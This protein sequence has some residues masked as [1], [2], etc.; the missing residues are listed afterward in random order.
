MREIR[1]FEV[2]MLFNYEDEGIKDYL[3]SAMDDWEEVDL[4]EYYDLQSWIN[5][6]NQ[7]KSTK[8][9][10]I[11]VSPNTNTIMKTC[12]AD[13]KKIRKE[14]EIRK[15]KQEEIAKKRAATVKLKKEKK[16]REK[17]EELQKKF[18]K[19]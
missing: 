15:A 3:V 2:S 7:D 14:D 4:D 17:F 12:L 13:Y 11:L 18:G 19:N 16:E 6:R 8:T 1:I 10:F 9:K 5:E